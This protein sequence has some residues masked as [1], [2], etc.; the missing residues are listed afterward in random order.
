MRYFIRLKGGPGSGHFGHKGIPGHRGGS[1]PRGKSNYRHE[2]R[3]PFREEI[4]FDD[5]ELSKAKTWLFGIN[6]LS[7]GDDIDHERFAVHSG[8]EQGVNDP[9]L[10]SRGIYFYLQDKPTVVIY[11]TNEFLR[12]FERTIQQ[13]ERRLD[14][15]AKDAFG[16]IN[17]DHITILISNTGGFSAHPLQQMDYN[18]YKELKFKGGLGS[19][20]FGHKG[21]PGLEGGSLPRDESQSRI[22]LTGAAAARAHSMIGN[23]VVMEKYFDG[24]ATR[25]KPAKISW[26]GKDVFD[27]N[28]TIKRFSE[29]NKDMFK[30]GETEFYSRVERLLAQSGIT[31]DDGQWDELGIYF[32]AWVQDKFED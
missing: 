20:H 13:V 2:P 9:N 17:K 15:F 26:D 12:D 11:N 19:G 4:E 29:R 32:D 30:F 6:G 24:W 23:K 7:I 1:L 31:L 21:R 10:L 25:Y 16:G 14:K 18:Y 27:L 22:S 5:K 3:S 8:Y 28:N